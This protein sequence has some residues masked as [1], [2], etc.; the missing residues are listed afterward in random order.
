[1]R[2]GSLIHKG[3]TEISQKTKQENWHKLNLKTQHMG[4]CILFMWPIL[5]VLAAKMLPL[6]STPFY[7]MWKIKVDFSAN[8]NGM[9]LGYKISMQ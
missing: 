9:S 3:I 1:M 4:L 2:S 5:R 6:P 8:L 7:V